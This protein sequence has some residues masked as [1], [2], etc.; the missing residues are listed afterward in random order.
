VGLTLP[1]ALIDVTQEM[2]KKELPCLKAT[3]CLLVHTQKFKLESQ[4]N[5]ELAQV[6]AGLV[7]LLA[8]ANIEALQVTH[9]IVPSTVMEKALD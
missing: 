8:F 7:V 4:L 9:C 6:Q 3:D 5:C 1:L 2:H